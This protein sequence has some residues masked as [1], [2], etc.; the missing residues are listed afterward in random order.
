MIEH[1]RYNAYKLN[2]LSGQ[3]DPPINSRNWISF[4][5]CVAMDSETQSLGQILHVPFLRIH[6][7][8]VTYSWKSYCNVPTE[9]HKGQ[10]LGFSSQSIQ[11]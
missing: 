11:K 3:L 6:H 2:S 7:H 5:S 1:H 4:I 8:Y 9:Q 10:V